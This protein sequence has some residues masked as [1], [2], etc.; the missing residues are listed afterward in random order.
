MKTVQSQRPFDL[1]CPAGSSTQLEEALAC[2]TAAVYA[3]L[4]GASARPDAFS[5]TY[6]EICTARARTKGRCELYVAVNNPVESAREPY[7][8]DAMERLAAVGIDAFIVSDWGLL[9][10][11]QARQLGI[12]LHLS[13]LAGVHNSL[14]VLAALE[15]GATQI[16]LSTNLSR[17]DMLP[18]LCLGDR[19]TFE[20]IASGGYCLFDCYRCRLPHFVRNGAYSTQCSCRMTIGQGSTVTHVQRWPRIVNLELDWYL[21]HGIR[22]F[23]AEGRSKPPGA[24]TEQVALLT[25][26]R[27]SGQLPP[28]GFGDP[29]AV[30]TRLVKC[31]KAAD[32]APMFSDAASADIRDILRRLWVS[33]AVDHTTRFWYLPLMSS[34]PTQSLPGWA[35]MVINDLNGPPFAPLSLSWNSLQWASPLYT[36]DATMEATLERMEYV[37]RQTGVEA[38]KLHDVGLLRHACRSGITAQV[39][40]V[41]D[42]FGW[43]ARARAPFAMTDRF[44]ARQGVSR[45][46]YGAD[47]DVARSAD[48]GH[49]CDLLVLPGRLVAL[50]PSVA[51]ECIGNG[52]DI[53]FADSASRYRTIGGMLIEQCVDVP[54]ERRTRC[55]APAENVA[56]G[57][58][59]DDAASGATQFIWSLRRNGAPN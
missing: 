20:V 50:I 55:L 29:Y 17:G 35:G 31:P 8:L 32:D 26:P 5:M 40:T 49:L 47:Q 4:S 2:G 52:C 24:L 6:E 42:R 45:Y 38:I 54:W 51:S 7:V 28:P 43:P 15:H 14:G 23:K 33:G 59:D 56:V 22:F 12:P 53:S 9:S 13:C 46:E 16:V 58:E 19:A 44:L 41:W 25:E 30:A 48:F 39:T 18:M 27:R 36:F 21:S 3:G 37:V 34:A 10:E 1:V 57:I 11:I